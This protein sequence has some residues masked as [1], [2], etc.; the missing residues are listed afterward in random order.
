MRAEVGVDGVEAIQRGMDR[1][2]DV[3][4]SLLGA[5]GVRSAVE[6]ERRNRFTGTDQ[7]LR[8][9]LESF[10]TRNVTHDSSELD[11]PEISLTA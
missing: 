5:V 10:E 2:R 4:P 6:L 1:T 11:R 9:V 3:E 7:Q 8:Q